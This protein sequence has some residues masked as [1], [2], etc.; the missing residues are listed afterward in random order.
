MTLQ[1]DPQPMVETRE[2]LV[3]TVLQV[4]ASPSLAGNTVVIGSSQL[5]AA[6]GGTIFLL[7]LQQGGTPTAPTVGIDT[8]SAILD[9]DGN[10]SVVLDTDECAPGADV[11][12]ADLA[13]APY[14]TALSTMTV[15]PPT[16]TPAG[17]TGSPATSGATV[18]EV[19]TGDTAA[20][21]DADVYAVFT[22]EA[23]PVYAEQAVEI[24][25]A[26]LENR[27]DGGWFW[28]GAEGSITGTG[29]NT[30]APLQS[31]LDDDGNALFLFMGSSCAAGP[32]Q[33][34]ADVLA[35]TDPTSTT[36]FLVDAARPTV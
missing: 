20:S 6:C 22:V 23:D 29:V 24:G 32:S 30:G 28:G 15:D 9:A 10:A 13:S 21:G 34:I 5:Q 31:V 1:I 14:L 18:G 2:G 35:G 36:T 11:V 12:E 19:V 4:E 8:I 25:S 27:C 7:S 26:Q 16:P 3:V 33:V 17:V